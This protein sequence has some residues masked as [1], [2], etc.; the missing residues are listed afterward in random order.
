MRFWIVKKKTT[1]DAIVT[2]VKAGIC[3]TEQDVEAL[4]AQYG[5]KVSW[6]SDGICTED[7]TGKKKMGRLLLSVAEAAEVLGVGAS[8]VYQLTRRKDFPAFKIGDKR[9]VIS[10]P[11][12]ERWVEAQIGVDVTA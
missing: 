11:A 4:A 10:A 2:A 8:T 5:D 3:K 6:A 1:E 9:T 7:V 12:L